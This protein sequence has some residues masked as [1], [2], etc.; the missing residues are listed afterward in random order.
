MARRATDDEALELPWQKLY[1]DA[2]TKA[3]WEKDVLSRPP[4]VL[5]T[6]TQGVGLAG[7]RAADE[8]AATRLESGSRFG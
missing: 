2:P 4:K 6:L 1:T 8:V 5:K 7:H 3:W